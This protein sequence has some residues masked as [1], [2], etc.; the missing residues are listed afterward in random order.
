MP[1]HK[2]LSDVAGVHESI[3]KSTVV[4]EIKKLSNI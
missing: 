2:E 3:M 4:R 1:H